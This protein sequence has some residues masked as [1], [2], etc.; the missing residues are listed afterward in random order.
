[1]PLWLKHYLYQNS[2]FSFKF[3]GKLYTGQNSI[4]SLVLRFWAGVGAAISKRFNELESSMKY[5]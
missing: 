3:Y 1:M 5:H 2:Y 4:I